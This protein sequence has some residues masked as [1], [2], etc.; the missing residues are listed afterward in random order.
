MSAMSD[1]IRCNNQCGPSEPLDAAAAMDHV[2]FVIPYM[3]SRRYGAIGRFVAL[4]CDARCAVVYIL[5]CGV[6]RFGFI[7]AGG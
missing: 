6:W 4:L 7:T 2:L 3:T 5:L 1:R